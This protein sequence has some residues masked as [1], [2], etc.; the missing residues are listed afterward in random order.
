MVKKY[1]PLQN[2]PSKNETDRKDINKPLSVQSCNVNDD[3]NKPLKIFQQNIRGVQGKIN[4]LMIKRKT[5]YNLF[6]RT[7]FNGI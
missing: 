6:D 1:N 2:S 4:E 7:S 5:K 3:I